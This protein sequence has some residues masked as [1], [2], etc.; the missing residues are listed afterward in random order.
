MRIKDLIE[1]NPEISDL[2]I[3]F[4]K[5]GE[6]SE[7]Q[8]LIATVLIGPDHMK[9]NP[10]YRSNCTCIDTPINRIDLGGKYQEVKIGKIPKSILRLDVHEWKCRRIPRRNWDSNI[11]PVY[12]LNITVRT[13]MIPLITSTPAEEEISQEVIKQA[14]PEEDGQL[15]LPFLMPGA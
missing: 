2:Q 13:S 8:I 9:Y 14:T 7:A 3:Y 11:F 15:T 4:R 5:G 10:E 1:S 12:E 6:Y